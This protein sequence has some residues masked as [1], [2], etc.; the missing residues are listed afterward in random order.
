MNFFHTQVSRKRKTL[1]EGGKGGGFTLKMKN[2]SRF[3][4][5][6]RKF[7]NQSLKVNHFF[8]F[9]LNKKNSEQKVLLVNNLLFI[10]Q[11]KKLIEN[12]FKQE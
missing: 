7:P 2:V 9:S 5:F 1:P 8:T 3:G 10:R 12:P 11:R 6:I 4:K